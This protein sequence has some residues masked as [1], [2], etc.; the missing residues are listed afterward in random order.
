MYKPYSMLVHTIAIFLITEICNTILHQCAAHYMVGYLREKGHNYD[1]IRVE[2]I[3]FRKVI[4]CVIV[5]PTPS[6][7]SFNLRS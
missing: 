5:S 2:S 3:T 4:G 6:R 7:L 1:F